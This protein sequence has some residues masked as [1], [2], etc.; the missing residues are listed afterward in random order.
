MAKASKK[1]QAADPGF[2]LQIG[3]QVTFLKYATP[4]PK[5]QKPLFKKGDVGEIVKQEN[6]SEDPADPYQSY[7]VKN[8]RTGEQEELYL[9]D[10]IELLETDAETDADADADADAED[11]AKKVPAKAKAKTT[12]KAPAKKT[13]AKPAQTTV[14]VEG[15][16][17]EEEALVLTDAVAEMVEGGHSIE[18]ARELLQGVSTSYFSLGGVLAYI[19]STNA[20]TSVKHTVVGENGKK[21]SV[22]YSD[23]FEFCAGELGQDKAKVYQ[24]IRIYRKLS[25]AGVDEKKFTGVGW[26]Y[27]RVMSQVIT[28]DNADKLLAKAHEM[29]RDAFEDYVRETY[30]QDGARAAAGTKIK[31]KRFSFSVHGDQATTVDKAV[32]ALSKQLGTDDLGVIFHHLAV[33]YL[34]EQ[35]QTTLEQDVQYLSET[36][37]VTLEVTGKVKKAKAAP[38]AA[39]AKKAAGKAKVKA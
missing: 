15:E 23:F 1:T 19:Q 36:H 29:P 33:A 16:D 39:P 34:Q 18:A 37:G 4:P 26:T 6:L 12:A 10:E 11:E 31:R 28:S 2:D 20:H 17:D 21:K 32:N 35:G 24:L 30:V 5:G 9:P 3:E 27:A 13:A 7:M 22:A 14:E 8:L 38:K 25:A